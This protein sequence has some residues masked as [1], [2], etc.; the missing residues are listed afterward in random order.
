MVQVRVQVEVRV[1]EEQAMLIMTKQEVGKHEDGG[2]DS[3]LVVWMVDSKLSPRRLTSV[4]GDGSASCLMLPFPHLH[5]GVLGKRPS[6]TKRSTRT[7]KREKRGKLVSIIPKRVL[8]M[9][10]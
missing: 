5:L 8:P 6:S 9:G 4:G 7:E 1:E 3:V 10:V 2:M